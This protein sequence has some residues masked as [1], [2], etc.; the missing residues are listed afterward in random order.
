MSANTDAAIDKS[1]W[2]EG[3]WHAEPDRAEWEHAGLPCL[4]VR[5]SRS[6]HWCGYAAVPP[7]H[8]LHGQPYDA[9]AVTV[10]VHGGLTYADRCHGHICHVPKPGAP[11]DVWW[12]GFDCAH[13]GDVSPSYV[14]QR[15]GQGYPWPEAPYDHA[16]AVAADRFDVERYRTLDYVRAET[17]RLAEQL[18]ALG[19]QAHE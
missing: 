19:P 18:A 3:P 11:D 17:N 12:F 9:E 8:P 2:G 6:G 13:A 15:V 7:S 10:D 16:A 4:A 14:N 5:H 1:A